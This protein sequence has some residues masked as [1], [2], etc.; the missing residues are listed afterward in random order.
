MKMKMSALLA[1]LVALSA[2]GIESP[3]GPQPNMPALDA[4]T[5]NAGRQ[6]IG[7]TPSFTPFDKAPMLANRDAVGAALEEEYPT[8]L[9]HAG[10]GGR[11]IVW[12]QIDETGIVRRVAINQTSGQPPLDE[13]ALRVAQ[14]MAFTPAL[15]REAPTPVWVSIPIQ[16]RVQPEE[17]P[18]R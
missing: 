6:P 5:L 14:K 9:R 4:N 1:A 12:I 15:L 2:C 7:D 8:L 13:A 18:A 11:A 17:A 3:S 16:F 10:I